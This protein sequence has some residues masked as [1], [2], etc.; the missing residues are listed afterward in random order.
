MRVKEGKRSRW[1]ERGDG[2]G[3]NRKETSEV[4]DPAPLHLGSREE[5]TEED[6]PIPPSSQ[7]S[8]S[9]GY[10]TNQFQTTVMKRLTRVSCQ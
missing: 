4:R 7:P 6:G 5:K 8:V 2:R 9:T 3:L 10:K 1:E